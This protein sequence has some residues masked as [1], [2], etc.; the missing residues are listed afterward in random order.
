MPSDAPRQTPSTSSPNCSTSRRAAA[1]RKRRRDTTPAGPPCGR[2]SS[3][4]LANTLVELCRDLVH[5]DRHGNPVFIRRNTAGK[6]VGI[7]TSA[8]AP[9]PDAQG[10]FWMSWKT[11]WR[12]HPR[13]QRARS[14]VDPIP[15]PRS[16][17]KCRMRRRLHRRRHRQHPQMDRGMEPPAHLLC[18]GHH[19]KRRPCRPQ[20]DPQG[21][22]NRPH[23]PRTRQSGLERHAHPRPRRRAP[24]N[25]RPTDQLNKTP[26]HATLLAS[27]PNRPP[28]ASEYL[29]FLTAANRGST[30][31]SDAV[32]RCSQ[33]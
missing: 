14:S 27:R 17:K 23:A 29:P 21:H 25:R 2:T 10:G 30:A 22:Q 11:D 18:L 5:A 32:R 31:W 12:R 6:P 3:S 15:A 13:R 28:S 20:P 24:R 9:E 8:A 19:P 33:A 26:P 4:G 1:A 16:G 7:E